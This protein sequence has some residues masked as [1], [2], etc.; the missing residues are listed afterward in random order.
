MIVEILYL[1]VTPSERPEWLAKD[2]EVWTHFLAQQPGFVRKEVWITDDRSEELI[3]AVWWNSFED[4]QAVTPERQVEVDKGMGLC[5][6][7]PKRME[8]KQVT[9]RVDN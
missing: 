2:A 9:L 6:R 1:N 8:L 5:S 3:I 4:F 7:P